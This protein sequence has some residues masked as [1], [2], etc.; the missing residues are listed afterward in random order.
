MIW[1]RYGLVALLILAFAA[2]FGQPGGGGGGRAGAGEVA[3]VDGQAIGQDVFEFWR[4]QRRR[5]A[6]ASD[7]DAAA[8]ERRLD[9]ETLDG[10][11]WEYTLSQEA[12]ALG[13][14]VTDE[15]LADALRAFPAFQ[16]GG[17]YDPELF[18]AFWTRSGFDSDR[19][20][21]EDQR[22]VLLGRR[23][24]RLVLGPI[25]VSDVQVREQLLRER[26][27]VELHYA[28]ARPAQFQDGI[29]IE[30]E[31]LR[32]FDAPERLEAA[33]QARIDEFRQPE[34]VRARHILFTGQDA[35]E[36]ARAALERLR[37]GEDFAALARELST[38]PATREAGGD[39]GFF[40]RGRMLLAFEQAAFSL[41]PGAH[42]E[43]VETE[44]GV[45]LIRL[46]A[47]RGGVGK[48]LAD[49]RDE[50]A[51]SLLEEDRA[52][53]AAQQAAEGLL[54]R[55]R[56]GE[57]FAVAARAQGLEPEETGAFGYADLAIPG[58]GPLPGLK[59]T[60][61]ELTSERPYAEQAFRDGEAFVVIGLRS[62][63]EP[64]AQTLEAELEPTRERLENLA[65]NH[66]L[67]SWLRERLD[68]LQRSGRLVR[69]PLYATN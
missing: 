24:R 29:Q 7:G 53:Q 40:P 54:A 2:F 69:Q 9:Q 49:V 25:R 14:E 5:A 55:L 18:E 22:R 51:R 58:L 26:L 34:E 66:L 56:A 13:I 8:Q 20:F 41:E 27:R 44:R 16:R 62:R 43:P 42:S 3:R 57:A 38:D 23:F 17:A 30:A 28:Q 10:L 65:R 48:T 31:D 67:S 6:P 46:E 19:T 33:Y 37:A 68:A 36:Q 39:L 59:E 61:L 63:D 12:R 21:L 11:I 35:A 45:H 47:R 64:D 32:D 50:L 4:D 15:E 1:V 60:A 52:R